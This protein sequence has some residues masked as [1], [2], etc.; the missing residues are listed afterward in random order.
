MYRYTP[1]IV[2]VI[3]NVHLCLCIYCNDGLFY[4]PPDKTGTCVITNCKVCYLDK[5][6]RIMPSGCHDKICQNW[7]KRDCLSK[8]AM[9]IKEN[10]QRS[11]YPV[12]IDHCTGVLVN[13]NLFVIFRKIDVIATWDIS[14]AIFLQTDWPYLLL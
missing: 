12:S 3:T 6:Q 5:H 11:A 2:T 4:R 10:F 1:V 7:R 9:C 13:C 14:S 8:W